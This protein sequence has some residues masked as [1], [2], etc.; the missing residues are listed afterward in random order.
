[1]CHIQQFDIHRIPRTL[2]RR[3][4]RTRRFHVREP[5]LLG[6]RSDL[7]RHE[8]VHIATLV[9]RAGGR[10]RL[11]HE[12]DPETRKAGDDHRKALL[13]DGPNLQPTRDDEA[14]ARGIEGEAD[15]GEDRDDQCETEDADERELLLWR[16]PTS[17]GEG[18]RNEGD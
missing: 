2:L 3:R 11:L 15:D 8:A 1:M 14:G 12:I 7:P 4:D 6:G 16:H 17:A 9:R 5:R 10:F 18:Q 13:D